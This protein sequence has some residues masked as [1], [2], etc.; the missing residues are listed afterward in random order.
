MSTRPCLKTDS[1]GSAASRRLGTSTMRSPSTHASRSMTPGRGRP[2][3]AAP[4]VLPR[5]EREDSRVG[6]ASRDRIQRAARR[7]PR[8]RITWCHP[9]AP[10]DEQVGLASV[11]RGQGH[12]EVNIPVRP[13]CRGQCSRRCRG[14][15]CHGLLARQRTSARRVPG[16]HRRDAHPSRSFTR[17][18][19]RHQRARLDAAE[20]ASNSAIL[21]VGTMRVFRGARGM[22]I[23]GQSGRSVST[24]R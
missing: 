23:T 11:G 15:S 1:P 16:L 8:R 12:Q 18:R 22:S 5:R 3:R 24:I 7:P 20:R 13:S 4:L 6:S 2:G 17:G 19:T 14:R 9:D 21:N 10:E